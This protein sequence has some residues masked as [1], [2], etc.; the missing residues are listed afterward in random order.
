VRIVIVSNIA[1]GIGL[2]RDCKLLGDWLVER[3]HFV[4]LQQYDA[5]AP[6]EDQLHYGIYDL[7]FF[8]ETMAEHLVPMAKRWHYIANPEWL[9]A[10]YVRPIQRHC[11]KIIA[12]TRDAERTLRERFSNV[13]YSGFLASS[14]RDTSIP[15]VPECLHIGGN[16][17]HR[18]TAAVISA[19]REYRYWDNESLPPL[20]VISNSKQ[21]EAVDCPGITFIRRATDEQLKLLQNSCL[22]HLQPSE[23]EGFGHAL[24]ESQSVGA[25]LLTTGAGPMA[26][27]HAPFEMKVKETKKA[28]QATLYCVSPQ[29]I[30]EAVPR[31]AALP[32]YEIARMQLEARARFEKGNA[33]FTERFEQLLAVSEGAAIT[34]SGGERSAAT[35][36]AR[37]SP[38]ANPLRIAML[39]NFGP[40]HSTENDW[41]WSFESLG[42]KVLTFQENEDRTDDILATCK[43]LK[44]NLFLYVHTHS[45][46]TPGRISLDDMIKGLRKAG[47]PTVSPH[48]DLYFGLNDGDGRDSRVGNHPFWH[49][50]LCLTADGSSQEKFAARG[51]NHSWLKPGVVARE[52]TPGT[53]QKELET[54]IAFVGSEN[55]HREWPWR[56]EMI[57]T[58]REV[59]GERF[60]VLTGFRGQRLNDLYASTKILIGDCC[61]AGK[62][63]YYSDRW[64][65]TCGRGGFL[66][67]PQIEGCCI[68]T[69]TFTSQDIHDL[70]DKVDYYLVHEDEREL[71]RRAA[72][73]HVKAHDTYTHRAKDILRMLNL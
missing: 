21:I 60:K 30:R 12:K 17:G 64:P 24:H 57:R 73:E 7:G 44:V 22:F 55:Y 34:V 5:P 10:E 37:L 9:K 4:C 53:F 42:H 29:E 1:N 47:I 58:L 59:Y 14:K 25:I 20:T 70:M 50:D 40:P 62:S 13:Y 66:L 2:E 18:G 23:Y 63:K 31:M 39:G 72:H 45:W 41:R 38:P 51:V 46:L 56:G 61:F 26:E 43:S 19:W 27:C 71:I 69:A 65:E 11:D 36:T 16:S 15:R 49:T 68:P 54:E 67:A 6:K 35:T 33:E 8:I 3:G 48:L 32:N 52:C 28:H